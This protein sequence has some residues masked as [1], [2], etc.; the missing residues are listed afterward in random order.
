MR[1]G[2]GDDNGAQV[3][4]RSTGKPIQFICLGDGLAPAS[5]LGNSPNHLGAGALVRP[6]ERGSAL[7]GRRI[8]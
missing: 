8:P 6:A 4:C 2:R 3:K 5:S 7:S 1:R